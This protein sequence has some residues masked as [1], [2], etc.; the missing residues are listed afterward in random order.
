[1]ART[2]MELFMNPPIVEGTEDELKLRMQ[3]E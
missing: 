3:E 1:M 2:T